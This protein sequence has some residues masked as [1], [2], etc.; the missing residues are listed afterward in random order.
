MEPTR[1][2]QMNPT[3]GYKINEKQL[4]TKPLAVS[5]N[6]LP[7]HLKGRGRAPAHTPIYLFIFMSLKFKI[8]KRVLTLGKR[9]GQTAYYAI[10]EEHPHTTWAEVEERISQST[11]I[12]RA[13]L[14]AVT[15]AL[16]DIVSQEIRAGR[17]VDLADLGSF[18]AVASGKMM[19][20]FSDVTLESLSRI[21]V[22]FYPKHSIRDLHKAIPLELLREEHHP[23]PK[24]GKKSKG[25]QPGGS[26]NPSPAPGYGGGGGVGI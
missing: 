6:F 2:S 19:D 14:R 12:S 22:R 16:H 8:A 23:R 15:V 7:L 9:R 17:S 1:G 21:C 4:I 5:K 24:K 25:T 3:S 11:T 10:Q 20:K 26:P 13:D 18:K